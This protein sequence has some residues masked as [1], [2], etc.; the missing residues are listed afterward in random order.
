MTTSSHSSN[1]G[2][3]PKL[4]VDRL[5]PDTAD[6]S[7]R[8]TKLSRFNTS[9]DL[10]AQL[11]DCHHALLTV[12]ENANLKYRTLKLDHVALKERLAHVEA[13]QEEERQQWAREKEQ[14]QRRIDN[15]TLLLDESFE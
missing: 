9:L 5:A 12:W 7:I 8:L 11:Q 14:L 15:K 10:K 4:T 6:R 1:G 13:A 3:W 2:S